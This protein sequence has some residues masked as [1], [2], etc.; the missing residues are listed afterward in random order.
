M[1]WDILLWRV[2]AIE[3]LR[4]INF[5]REFD[6]LVFCEGGDYDNGEK[7]VACYYCL[8]YFTMLSPSSSRIY[9]I[10]MQAKEVKADVK[11]PETFVA[12]ELKRVSE[13]AAAAAKP[14]QSN[15]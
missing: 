15:I 14:Q 3:F 13:V 11:F 5:F 12:C 7:C 6:I 2:I 9:N 8:I 4:E 10:N 1:K